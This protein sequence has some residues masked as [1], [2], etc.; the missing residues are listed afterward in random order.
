MNV[1]EDTS[2]RVRGLLVLIAVRKH[3]PCVMHLFK[4]T[5]LP[6]SWSV[7]EKGI[8]GD[9]IKKKHTKYIWVGP[10]VWR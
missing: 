8:T 3:I 6:H 1:L 4:C 2:Y 9:E 7:Q 10:E 5:W